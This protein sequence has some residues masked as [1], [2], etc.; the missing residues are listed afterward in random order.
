VTFKKL[1][2]GMISQAPA[3]EGAQLLEFALA[4]P[5]LIAMLLGTIDLGRLAYVYIETMNAA[6]AG[7]AYG[8]QNHVTAS[9]N[10]GM[11]N[12]AVNDVSA[13]VTGLTATPTHFCKCANGTDSPSCTISVCTGTNNPLVEYVQVDTTATYTAWFRFPALPNTVAVKG[14][15]IMRTGQ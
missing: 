7:V 5:L 2:R 15:A 6:R 3:E 9:D 14:Q 10:A 1:K 12:A 11:T 13:N 8:A 4:L